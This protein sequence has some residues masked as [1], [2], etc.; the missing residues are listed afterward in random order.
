[1]RRGLRSGMWGG[2]ELFHVHPVL[3]VHA[4]FIH[5]GIAAS[6][7]DFVKF[8]L[9]HFLVMFLADGVYVADERPVFVDGA[10]VAG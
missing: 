10:L 6:G 1:M 7:G 3:G 4:A 9:W 8:F 2:A 5:E